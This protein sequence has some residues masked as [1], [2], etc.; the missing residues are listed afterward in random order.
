MISIYLRAL[1]YTICNEVQ[2]QYPLIRPTYI[3]Q[4]MYSTE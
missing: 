1:E 2:N 4:V 3:M